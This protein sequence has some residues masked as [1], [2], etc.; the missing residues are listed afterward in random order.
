MSR[1]EELY[2][3]EVGDRINYFFFFFFFENVVRQLYC[4]GPADS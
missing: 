4:E 2:Q 1:Y 3:L